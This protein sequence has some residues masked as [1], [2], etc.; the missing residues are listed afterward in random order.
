M[1]DHIIEKDLSYQDAD[2][3]DAKKEDMLN[4]CRELESA[5]RY[6]DSIVEMSQK[7]NLELIRQEAKE[8]VKTMRSEAERIGVPVSAYGKSLSW[9]MWDI[10]KQNYFFT[11]QTENNPAYVIGDPLTSEAKRDEIINRQLGW[12]AHHAYR[13]DPDPEWKQKVSSDPRFVKALELLNKTPKADGQ[14]SS[15]D[16][17]ELGKFLRQSA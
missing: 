9:A 13:R 4:R 6:A 10:G 14:L 15:R 5:R 7:T 11:H 17:A 1:R 8:L 2:V 12:E 3:S 16:L